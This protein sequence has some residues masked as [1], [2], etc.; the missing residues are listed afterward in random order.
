MSCDRESHG[1][2]VGKIF[3]PVPMLLAKPVTFMNLSGQAV[4]GLADFHRVE[5]ADVLIY[6]VGLAEQCDVDLGDPAH[7]QPQGRPVS[8]S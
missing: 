4:R 7:R 6:L 1:A 3:A 2:L 8:R 5:L